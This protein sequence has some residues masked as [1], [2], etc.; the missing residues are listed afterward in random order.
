[1]S[2]PISSVAPIRDIPAAAGL[3]GKTGAAP[4]GAFEQIVHDAIDR[5]E[6]FERVSKDKTDR[7]LAGENEEVHEVALANART[8]L[9][10][11]MFVQTRNKVVQAYQEIMRMQM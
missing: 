9:A 8:G 1:M 6:Q 5:V 2:M 7:F 4:K 11:E 10:F 3:A